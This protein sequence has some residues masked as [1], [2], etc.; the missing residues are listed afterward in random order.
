[1]SQQGASGGVTTVDLQR[2]VPVGTGLG[3]RVR[4]ERSDTEPRGAALV[5]YHGAYG[6][7]EGGIDSENG[8]LTG[9][10]RAAGALVFNAREER[11][12][13]GWTGKKRE[14]MKGMK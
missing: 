10:S 14:Q 12:R 1:M 7:L 9:V 8:R 13:E 6:T 5:Q 2:W 4:L 3:Y 11:V